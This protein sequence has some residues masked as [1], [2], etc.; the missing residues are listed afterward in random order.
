MANVR[1]STCLSQ[2][3]FLTKAPPAVFQV[4]LVQYE[5]ATFTLHFHDANANKNGDGNQAQPVSA[6][7][8]SIHPQQGLSQ[9]GMGGC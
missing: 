8:C 5:T 1:R 3:D 7:D 4:Q 9:H 6:S 2:R